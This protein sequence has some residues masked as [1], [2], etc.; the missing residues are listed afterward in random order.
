MERLGVGVLAARGFAG[1]EGTGVTVERPVSA[2][3]A[4][5]TV[6]LELG[7]DEAAAGTEATVLAASRR[8]REATSSPPPAARPR[9]AIRTRREECLSRTSGGGGP[10]TERMVGTPVG[11]RV[12]VGS[13]SAEA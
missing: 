8:A 3:V 4:G 1:G 2:R 10:L 7:A 13:P 5:A 12:T 9:A 11:V 6:T